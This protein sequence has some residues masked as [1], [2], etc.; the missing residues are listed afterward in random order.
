MRVPYKRSEA[1]PVSTAS[2]KRVEARG[3][4]VEYFFLSL[5]C[6]AGTGFRQD[7]QRS[8]L[9]Q[10]LLHPMVL[11]TKLERSAS[12]HFHGLSI[13]TEVHLWESAPAESL[14]I[15]WKLVERTVVPL[16]HMGC[17]QVH[18]IRLWIFLMVPTSLDGYL[19][20]QGT[21]G[22]L[23]PRPLHQVVDT[24]SKPRIW[25]CNAAAVSLEDQPNSRIIEGGKDC[26]RT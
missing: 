9:E 7:G 4:T 17:T 8:C 16:K 24:V 5:T 19:E 6:S 22:F 15:A 11:Y 26:N 12:V 13:L 23:G 10:A 25:D 3:I 14:R 18:K 20:P 1:L 21:R 2:P